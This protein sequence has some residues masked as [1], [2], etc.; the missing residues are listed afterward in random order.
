MTL[1][2]LVPFD[3]RKLPSQDTDVLVIG[4]G[5]A[6]LRAAIEASR[7]RKVLMVTKARKEESNSYYAQGGIAAA[8]TEQ[9]SFDSHMEDTMRVSCGLA[10]PGMVEIVV[11]E[12]ADRVREL[13]QWRTPFDREGK[14]FSLA[15]EGG[16]SRAR[17]LHKG[18]RTGAMLSTTLLKRAGK[19]ENVS[20]VSDTFVLDL[21][22]HRSACVGAVLWSK[23]KGLH[24]VRART[25]ILATGGAGQLYRETT[26][27]A[28]ATGD[29]IAMAWRAGAELMDLEFFQFH[30]TTLYLAGASRALITEAVR[31]EGGV[32]RD[33]KG[34]AFM[35]EY[36]PMGDLAPRDVVSRAILDHMLRTK[37]TQ[38]YLDVRKVKRV[39]Q[40]FPGL[41]SV[42]DNYKL[43]LTKD[44]IPVRPSAHYMIG[45]IRV[46]SFG[47]TSVKNLFACGECATSGF[48]GANRL[49]SNSLLECV[50]FGQR[51]GALAAAEAS[52]PVPKISL[53]HPGRMHAGREL[54]ID[55]LRNSLRSIMWRNVG[56]ER[57]AA[58]LKYALDSIRFWSGYVLDRSFDSPE[59]WELQ[60]LMTLA[61]LVSESALYRKESR[62]VHTRRDHPKT[63]DR[64]WKKRL[65]V[66][67]EKKVTETPV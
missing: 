25:T 48:H 37:D 56:V 17:I 36:H 35:K 55:D 15:M 52:K 23:E 60:N 26:N 47:R 9:D 58:G 50:V 61:K 49:A 21:V 38:V 7:Q 2:Y 29:G 16:H 65:V 45:G 57:D 28:V 53:R 1:R 46:D 27:P 67:R 6:A 39:R 51:A 41:A 40:R 8:L 11:R 13:I 30:P 34:R 20:I 59:A 33:R 63:N 42:A 32:L 12:G 18:D 66:R 22:T 4:S 43:K 44:L 19:A 24:W 62:G 54:D 64:R 14:K 31:G 10:D 3:L 5:L